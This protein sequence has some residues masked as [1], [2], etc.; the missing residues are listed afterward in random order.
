MLILQRNLPAQIVIAIT[1]DATVGQLFFNELPPFIPHQPMTT[2][3]GIPDPGQL[4]PLVVAVIRRVALRINP[5]GDIA[6]LITLV[7]P[8]RL[9]TPHDPYEAFVML[10]GRRLI[11]PR[12][13]RDQAS[14]VVV[15]IR[16]HRA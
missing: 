7:F 3:V 8:N 4:S 16:R 1:L 10:V 15:L 6:L 9:T 12:K 13:Q 14:G 5:A 11:L 2:V